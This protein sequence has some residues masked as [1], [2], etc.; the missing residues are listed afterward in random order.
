MSRM[1]AKRKK[2][3]RWRSSPPVWDSLALAFPAPVSGLL[4]SAEQD[5]LYRSSWSCRFM[6]KASLWV[7]R[8]I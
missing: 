8:Q 3:T 6:K 1:P 7:D 5:A 4:K 2:P